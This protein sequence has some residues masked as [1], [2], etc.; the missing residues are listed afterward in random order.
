M[1]ERE[2]TAINFSLVCFKECAEELRPQLLDGND[3]HNLLDLARTHHRLQEAQ[4]N[5]ELSTA[6]KTREKNI[7]KHIR[8]ITHRYKW[9]V[10][11]NGDPRG[12]SVKI[13]FPSRTSN[14]WGGETWGI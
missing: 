11:F 6:Q 2:T 1:N 3:I 4:C 10:E 13:K 14:H 7:E 5:H 9:G 8:E 12:F